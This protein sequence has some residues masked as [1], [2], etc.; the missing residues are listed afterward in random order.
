[1]Y[2]YRTME[3]FTDVLKD[4]RKLVNASKIAIRDGWTY[5]HMEILADRV[6]KL[7]TEVDTGSVILDGLVKLSITFNSISR[8]PVKHLYPEV[9]SWYANMC[10]KDRMTS[11]VGVNMLDTIVDH[12]EKIC[13]ETFIDTDVRFDDHL[14]VMHMLG[15]LEV[16]HGE[17]IRRLEERIAALESFYGI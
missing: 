4:L 1:M 15:V 13:G 9:K 17:K 12:L 6:H 3:G 8:R 11:M 5:Q 2:K 14:Y 16:D 7:A 10:S